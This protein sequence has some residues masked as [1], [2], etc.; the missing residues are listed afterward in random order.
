MNEWEIF[1]TSFFNGS[2]KGKVK[3]VEDKVG[4]ARVWPRMGRREKSFSQMSP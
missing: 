2:K 4:L 3:S 1:S